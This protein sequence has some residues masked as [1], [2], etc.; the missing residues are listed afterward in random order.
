MKQ[1]NH[2]LA[3][4]FDTDAPEFARGVEIGRLW[5]RLRLDA[6]PADEM[7]HIANTEMLLRIGDALG[8]AVTGEEHDEIWMTVRFGSADD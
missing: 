5:E 3:L 2:A 7:V 4:A 6:A 8:R 1:E